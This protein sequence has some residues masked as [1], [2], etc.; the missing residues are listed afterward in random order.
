MHL[1]VGKQRTVQYGLLNDEA[2]QDYTALAVLE[3]YIYQ[4]PQTGEP[5]IS[6]DR[7]WQ[8]FT[9]TTR[10][11]DG[12]TRHAFRAAIWVT[13]RCRAI[14]IPVDSYDTAAVLLC[15][16]NR[17]LLV[18]ASYEARDGRSTA[19]R[20]AALTRRLRGLTEA[21]Q[22][23]TVETAGIPLD[24]LFCT[25]FNRHHELW[26]GVRASYDKGRRNEGEPFV[27]L[28]QEAGLH[29]LLPAGTI[30]W[31]HQS[32]D[33]ASTVDVLAGSEEIVRHLEYCRI[34][35]TDYGSDHRPIALS[36]LGGILPKAKQRRKRLYKDANWGEIRT[37]IGSLLG[38]GSRMRQ[39]TSI[40]TFERAAGAFETVINNT[41]EEHVLRAK[42]SPYAKRWWS[43]E[44][45]LLRQ[46]YTSKRNKAITLRRR[47]EDTTLAREASHTARR[48][49]LDE[50]NKQK[51]QHWKDFLNDPNNIWKAACYAK[52]SGA[53]MDVPDLVTNGQRYKTDEGKAEVLMATFFPTPPIPEGPDPERLIGNS[54]RHTIEWPPLTKHEAERAIFR[55]NPDKAPGPDEISFRVWRELWPVVGDHILWLYNTSLELHY[56][57]RHWK[58]ARIVTLRK[59]G[60]GDYT[61]PEAFRPISLLPTISKGLEAAVAA[62]LSFITETYNLLPSNHF[63]ARPRRSAEQALN[64]LVEKIYQAWRQGRVLSLVSFDVQ[65]AF[66]GVHSDV[67]E[68]RLAARRVPTPAVKWIRDFCDGRHAQVTVGSFESAVSPIKYAGIPQGS[69]LSPLLYVFYNADLVERKIDA[70]GGA[71]GFVDDFNAWVVGDDAKQN[72]K[73]IQD[74]IIPHAEQWASR[75]GATFE[76]RKT[77]FIHFTRKA[78]LENPSNLR[79]G[80]KEIMPSQSVKVLGVTLDARL[81]MDEHISRVTT[82]GIKACLSLQAIKGVRP[83]QMRQLFRSCVLPIIDYAASTWFGPGQRGVIRL[84][85]ALEKV[86]RIGA[87][88]ILRAWKAVALPILEAEANI[89]ATKARLTRKVTAHAAKLLALPIDNPVRKALVHARRTQRYSSP[90]S[91]T[92]AAMARKLKNIVTKPLLGNPPWIHATWVGLGRRVLIAERAQAITDANW[93]AQAGVASLYPDASVT[94]RCT[95][96]A[97]TRRHGDRATVV[98]QDSI[99]WSSTCSILTA[100]I[101]AIAAALDYARESFESGCREL[102]LSATRLQV[103]I[104]SDSQLALGAIQAG[105]SAKCG[106]SLLRKIAES[107]FALQKKGVDIEFRWVPGHSGVCGNTQA[108]EAARE[109]ANR[110]GGLTA[111]LARRIR[112]VT[113]VIRL[114]EQD[115][116]SDSNHFD[117]DG[118]PGQY[119]WKLDQALPG[120]HTLRL[121]GALTSE[122]A[123]IL[124]QARTGHCRLNQYLSRLGVVEEAKC[125]CGID[126]ETIRHILCVCPLWATQRRTLQAVAGDRQGDVSYLLGGWGKRKDPTSGR[127]LDGEKGSWKP[128]LTVVKAT[129]QFLQE[130]GRLTYQPEEG[131]VG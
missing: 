101:A 66:N 75:S 89:E 99:G 53:P 35:S 69:P 19:E 104:F 118:L 111:P 18:A 85:N 107:F 10:R 124:I 23:A 128:D 115:R 122:Q 103:A 29:S 71:L 44:L 32:G 81:S 125:R 96:V 20:E 17:N 34:H 78:V 16:Q 49:Y 1:N 4:H 28:I 43:K 50:I 73:A 126:D 79:F 22:L 7:H 65:G 72:T 54:E 109:A 105:N 36:Y 30:T 46:D 59:P 106:R 14:Q 39:I 116:A 67:L 60:K 129:V 130:T 57:P 63:G 47:G 56:T 48:V 42:E 6:P 108:D 2:L 58:T 37:V 61:L 102:L 9:P 90:L 62:R 5:T 117:P 95:A 33:I 25:D 87:R 91:T 41:L 45:T 52:P 77:S 31:E 93:M 114:I 24:V 11:P 55:S 119:T 86:Q 13:K 40:D 121:Y 38:D 92:M 26:G 12:H 27:D 68:R 15:L 120:R 51:K 74:T 82:K 97:V 84:C 110:E 8:V 64:V 113:R 98:V 21:V 70:N 127:L 3:P 123:S 83:K 88:A 131:Q 100:E 94:S 112:E 80:N 76:A